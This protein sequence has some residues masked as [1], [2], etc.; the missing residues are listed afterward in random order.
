MLTIKD[1]QDR[2]DGSLYYT[3]P[4]EDAKE[5]IRQEFAVTEQSY[6]VDGEIRHTVLFGLMGEPVSWDNCDDFGNGS[7]SEEAWR[8]A[9]AAEF[10]PA[11]DEFSEFP[12]T[13]NKAE[14]VRTLVDHHF[15]G[16]QRRDVFYST[17]TA[18]AVVLDDDGHLWQIYPDGTIE[19]YRH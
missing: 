4:L 2:P 8:L 11:D 17:T 7:T 3:G 16:D 14:A 6:W 1:L 10:G 9:L 15:P 19:I 12:L 13:T 18:H 5:F